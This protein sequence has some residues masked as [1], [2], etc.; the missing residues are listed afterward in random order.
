M[1]THEGVQ[2]CVVSA[3]RVLAHQLNSVTGPRAHTILAPHNSS[4]SN[5]VV[6][7]ERGGYLLLPLCQVIVCV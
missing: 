4:T 3:Q 2:P 6:I 1:F 5:T 7:V